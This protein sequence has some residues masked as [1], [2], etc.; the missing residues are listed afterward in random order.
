MIKS[1]LRLLTEITLAGYWPGIAVMTKRKI[2]TLKTAIT[3]QIKDPFRW[4]KVHFCQFKS[5]AAIINDSGAYALR[6]IRNE[7]KNL[8]FIS[9]FLRNVLV[10]DFL[11]GQGDDDFVAA[12]VKLLHLNRPFPNFPLGK[13]GPGIE[14][15][16]PTEDGPHLRR[17]APAS[18]R[19]CALVLRCG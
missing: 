16:I 15:A 12:L 7:I 2:T 17:S 14:A 10:G 4:A 9:Q 19:L 18:A 11:H 5:F 1:P 6:K 13:V 3:K 8:G